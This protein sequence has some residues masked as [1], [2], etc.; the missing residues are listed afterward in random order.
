MR[1]TC[2]EDFSFTF[3]RTSPQNSKQNEAIGDQDDEDGDYLNR[4]S[5]VEEEKLVD[6]GVRTRNCQERRDVTENMTDF[7]GSTKGQSES[8]D[9]VNNSM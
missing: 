8:S 2:R 7:I 6:V 9:S 5:T 3:S 4:P 1:A